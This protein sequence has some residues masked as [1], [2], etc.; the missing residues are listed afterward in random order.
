MS[1]APWRVPLGAPAI[2]E[3]DELRCPAPP[4]GD[5]LEREDGGVG[6]DRPGSDRAQHF[7]SVFVDNVE[8]LD[9]AAVGGDAE[10][11]VAGPRASDS[12]IILTSSPG[13]SQ[14]P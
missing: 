12:H 13:A 11:V 14:R 2:V 9:R 4:G 1:G 5:G 10:I 8:D 6:V 3:P 7:A